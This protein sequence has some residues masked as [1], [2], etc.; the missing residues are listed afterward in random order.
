MSDT[1]ETHRPIVVDSIDNNATGTEEK[2]GSRHRREHLDL[3]N[4]G[5]PYTTST[6]SAT[7]F[8]DEDKLPC[9]RRRPTDDPTSSTDRQ[10]TVKILPS[11]DSPSCSSTS[12]P[13]ITRLFR[14]PKR[15]SRWLGTIKSYLSKKYAWIPQNWTWCKLKPVIRCAL[16]GW[17]SV[18][19]FVIPE[20]GMTMNSAGFLILT[21][22]FWS[23]PSDPFIATF[24]REFLFI[25]LCSLTWAWSCLGIFLAN[26]ARHVH[27]P[28]ATLAQVFTGQYVEAGPSVVIGIFLFFGSA[29]L[30]WVRAN[31]GPG[32][33]FFPC[34]ISCLSMDICLTTAVL[35]PYP[36]YS[37][38]RWVL[39]P[40]ALHTA[41]SL[42]SCLVI[43]PST[44][45]ATFTVRLASSL[46]PVLS[47]LS[48]N[49]KLLATPLSS[50][51]FPPLLAA[52]RNDTT[53]FEAELLSLASCGR[54]LKN[55]LIYG[56]FAPTDFIA[57]QERFK[58]LAGRV[59]GLGVYFSLIDPARERFPGAVP[60]SPPGTS[61]PTPRRH[62]SRT[63]SRLSIAEDMLA[64]PP[65]TPDITHSPPSPSTAHSFHLSPT[66]HKHPH[67]QMHSTPRSHVDLHA[68]FHLPHSHSHHS[69]NHDDGL[70]HTMHHRLLHS[71]LLSLARK[72]AKSFEYAVGT[73][74]SQRYMNLEAKDFSDPREDEWNERMKT[75]VKDS[76]TPLLELCTSGVLAAQSWM[77][78]LRNG[79]LAELFASYGFFACEPCNPFSKLLDLVGKG[80]HRLKEE[81]LNRD[82]RIREVKEVRERLGNALETFRGSMRHAVLEPYQHAFEEED[83]T[84]TS[85]SHQFPASHSQ[86]AFQRPRSPYNTPTQEHRDDLFDGQDAHN[87]ANAG[88]CEARHFGTQEE[89]VIPPPRC[90]FNCFLYQYNAMQIASIILEVLDEI[91]RLEESRRHCQLWTPLQKIIRNKWSF[92]S[93]SV[94]VDYT[95]E[96]DDPDVIQGRGQE[97]PV[98]IHDRYPTE[99]SMMPSRITGPAFPV[100]LEE[101]L[102]LPQRRDPDHLPPRNAF[103]LIMRIVHS[104]L[105]N[106]G[107]GNVLFA[108][109]GGLL[110]VVLALPGL[111]R[112]S[113]Q[114]AYENRFVWAVFM[115]QMALSRF[116]GDTAFALTARITSTFFGAAVGLVMWYMSCGTGAGNPYGLAAICAICFPFFFYGRLYWPIP[117]LRNF[118]FFVTISMV[119]GYS[120]QDARLNPPHN[121]GYGWSIAWRRFVAVTCGVSAAFIAS[122]F[123]P[124]TTIRRYQR[125]L[126]STTSAELGTVYC[127]ILSFANTKYEPEIQEIL[128]TLLAVRNK[129]ARL[130]SL[131][132]NVGYEFSLKGQW[133]ADRYQKIVDLQIGITYSLTHLM[134]V[135]EHMDPAWS[136]AFLRRTRFMDPDFQGDVLAV[137]SMMTFALRNGTP[138]PQIT[139]CPLIDRFSFKYRGLNASHKDSEAD[140]GLPR[141]LSMDTLKDEQYLMFCVGIATAYNI[142]SRLDRL[143]IAVKEVVGEQYHIHG[144]GVLRTQPSPGSMGS[145]GFSSTLGPRSAGGVP[146]G[147]RTHTVHFEPSSQV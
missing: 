119:I 108:I 53:A 17:I 82:E 117:I 8:Q 107:S 104:C 100:E 136:R 55:D 106:L 138:L 95:A 144:V 5:K 54:L 60:T 130:L 43:F 103:E 64:N 72:R 84:K 46:S 9:H 26:L 2:A 96:D 135:L 145:V 63:A 41:V 146:M 49:I 44:V 7:A 15:M 39:I 97:N 79:R 57:F 52:I 133:P 75:L 109:K 61:P 47:T 71:S 83:L 143:M 129:I 23:P 140:Y 113:A 91:L 141:T 131:R 132:A 70:G 85:H 128:S 111:L 99:N 142:V 139:P 124:S 125:H 114:I 80:P 112:H 56:R 12:S 102:G 38:V 32:P 89:S 98:G 90:L 36:F 115:G 62:L 42:L 14:S 77:C 92:W 67:S 68:M 118:V 122:F 87:D 78:N 137:I 105:L 58:R 21:A 34:I 66:R 88:E 59:N 4:E 94:P 123:P 86:A 35:F 30:L 25:L 134:S 110:S 76:C 16:A 147:S 28:D 19:L 74:E 93:L 48:N 126:L 121:P 10:R 101:D 29:F 27:V 50:A 37:I 33:F 120:Y 116:Q 3:E 69:Q 6:S 45:S 65:P 20:V 127:S 11:P 31:R 81:L 18:V 40:V 1:A 13:S 24:E 73:F 22:A 51:E